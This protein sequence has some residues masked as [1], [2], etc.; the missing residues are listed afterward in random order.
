M[1]QLKISLSRPGLRCGYAHLS[2]GQSNA[3]QRISDGQVSGTDICRPKRITGGSDNPNGVAGSGIDDRYTTGVN[4]SVI[5][6]DA[7]DT[8]RRIG[9]QRYLG[10]VNEIFVAV[11]QDSLAADAGVVGDLQ[12]QRGIG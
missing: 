6:A 3:T 5:D 4:I 10:W 1:A 9:I 2:R 11:Q 7:I 8:D 12:R